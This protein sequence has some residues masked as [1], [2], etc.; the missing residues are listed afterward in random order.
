MVPP[1]ATTEGA[2]AGADPARRRGVR[3]SLGVADALERESR[4]EAERKRRLLIVTRGGVR[5]A[6]DQERVTLGRGRECD[7]VVASR[8]VSRLHAAIVRRGAELWVEDLGS[9]N[10]TW[11]RGERVASRRLSNGDEI[12]LCDEPVRCWLR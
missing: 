9:R 5:Q 12:R 10:G 2:A 3:R 7:I 4:A 6:P 11:L 1:P 8:H